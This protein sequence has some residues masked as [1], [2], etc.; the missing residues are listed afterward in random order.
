MTTAKSKRIAVY[1]VYSDWSGSLPSIVSEPW[2]DYICFFEGDT[3]DRHDGW[4]LREL[5]SYVE[6]DSPRSSRLPKILPHIYLPEYEYSIYVDTSVELKPDLRKNFFG[7]LGDSQLGLVRL[8][9]TLAQEFREVSRRRYDNGFVLLEQS[10]AYAA[11]DE[12]LESVQAYWG[13][14]ILRKHNERQIIE[15][16]NRW[17]TNVLRFSRRDQ[18]SLPVALIGFPKTNLKVIDG[19][20]SESPMHKRLSGE[21]KRISYLIGHTTGI[22]SHLRRANIETLYLAEIISLRKLYSTLAKLVGRKLRK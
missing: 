21:K 16:A 22:P 11:I 7:T 14:M 1:T 3:P 5:T 10:Q 13:G 8:P 20:D 17:I 2:V 9:R 6:L 18:L 19:S 15:F 12:P 4:V